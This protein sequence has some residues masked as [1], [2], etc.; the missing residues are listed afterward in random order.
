[1]PNIPGMPSMDEIREKVPGID[2]IKDDPEVAELMKNPKVQALM[3]QM[4]TNPMAAVSAMSD[5]EIGPA[6][7]KIIGKMM[8]GMAG[9]FGGAGGAG[10]MD[11]SK[12]FGQK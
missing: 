11:F 3:A 4:Q 8:P 6:F 1:M 7:Q 12:M 5:P 2:G 10:G 9:M